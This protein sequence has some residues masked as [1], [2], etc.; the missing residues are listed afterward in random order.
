MDRNLAAFLAVA[1]AGTLSEAALRLSI[2]QPSITKRLQN[3]EE[4]YECKLFDRVPR[5][6]VLT[7]TG[8]RFLR[9]ATR[10]EQEL[11]Q[12]REMIASQKRSSLERLRIGS[13]PLFH[14][15]YMAQAWSRHKREFPDLRL[16]LEAGVNPTLLPKLRDGEIDIV[17][18]TREVLDDSDPLVFFPLTPVD[19]GVVLRA[20][21]AIAS[22][23]EVTADDLKDLEWVA[24]ANNPRFFD[25]I[26]A[27]F[28]QQGLKPPSESIRTNSFA[29]GLQYVDLG[30]AVMT[31]PVQLGP[32]LRMPTL[33]VLRCS[34]QIS[35]TVGGAFLR[36][37]SL[38]IDEAMH[39][40][41]VVRDL[42]R[43]QDVGAGG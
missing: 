7:R 8:E 34:P 24:Y 13:G 5:G 20:D 38:E 2:S 28:D 3:L 43:E 41:D 17:F 22:K 29:M 32:V 10:I 35:S 25:L 9:H 11:V 31:A 39:M 19:T 16:Q 12:A 18:G 14:L 30:N 4:M 23:P 15:R 27:F 26:K 37:S 33:K 36:R 21:M 40:V 42:C 6:M 1:R